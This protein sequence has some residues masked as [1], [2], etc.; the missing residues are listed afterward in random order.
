VAVSW[1]VA[2]WMVAYKPLTV[3]K[4]E[5]RRLFLEAKAVDIIGLQ[6]TDGA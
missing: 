6:G 5:A 3:N 1:T 4:A 2:P